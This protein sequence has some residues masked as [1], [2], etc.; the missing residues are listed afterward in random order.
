MI[1]ALGTVA[2][3]GGAGRV[4]GLIAARFVIQALY[5]YPSRISRRRAQKNLCDDANSVV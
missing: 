5:H 3:Y 4:R 2:K 1:V